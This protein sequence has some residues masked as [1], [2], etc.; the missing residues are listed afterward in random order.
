MLYFKFRIG[1]GQIIDFI[2][3]NE[4]IN[5]VLYNLCVVVKTGQRSDTAQN[6]NPYKTPIAGRLTFF[7]TPIYFQLGPDRSRIDIFPDFEYVPVRTGQNK[8]HNSIKDGQ[9]PDTTW[10]Q[11]PDK[12]RNLSVS[13]RN[14]IRVLIQIVSDLYPSFKL[15]MCFILSGPNWHGYN[16]ESRYR[17]ILS[18]RNFIRVLIQ[19]VSYLFPSF[20]L[21]MCFILT[22]P[23]Q[24]VYSLESKPV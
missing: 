19:V 22:G 18:I 24:H 16:L 3:R 9:R 14:F 2:S 12:V 17:Y 4:K 11:D 1:C 20:I 15:L 10:N 5:Q 8:T 21:F 23:N 6:K 13:I 7:I